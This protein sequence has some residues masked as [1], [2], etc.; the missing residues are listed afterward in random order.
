MARPIAPG[1]TTAYTL[2]RRELKGHLE[3][4]RVRLRGEQ[5]RRVDRIAAD[6]GESSVV[7]TFDDGAR[8]AYTAA[9]R[10]LE[11]FGWLGH[12]FITTDWIGRP[13]FLE[14][15]QIRE[16]HRRGH[17]IG[18]HSRT[19]PERMSELKWELLVGE[20]RAS[21]AELGDILGEPVTVASVPGG[22]SSR[23]VARA[24]AAAGVKVLFTSEPTATASLLDGCLVLGRYSVRRGTPA[25][26]VGNIAAGASWPRF[27]QAALWSAKGIAKRIAG[28]RYVTLRRFL[29]NRSRSA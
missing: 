8:S 4:I 24:A 14:P 26:V 19:H 9:A 29:L 18:S 3:A 11:S 28:E 2:E 5:V 17:L 22:Y 6:G 15:H 21:C 27:Q 7:L 10:E 1:H 20:W 16:L 25:S 12:F 13:G 23:K